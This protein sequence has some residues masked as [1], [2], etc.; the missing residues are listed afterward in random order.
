MTSTPS[1]FRDRRPPLGKVP[2]VTAFFWIIKVLC[3]TVGETASDFLNVNIG[4]GLK[5]TAVVAGACLAIVLAVQFAVKKYIP[6]IY[7]LAVVLVSIF[8]TLVTDIL[9][10]SIHVPLEASAAIFSV[11]LALTFT[12]WY[13]TERTLS[14]HSI[15]TR[16]REAFY[17]LAILFTFALGTATG[18]LVAEKLGVGYLV[19]GLLVIGVIVSSAIAWRLGLDSVLAFWIAYILTRPLGASLG[20]YLSQP[21]ADGGLGLG[22]TATSAVFLLLI[23]AVVG[24][25]AVS[26]KD[27]FEQPPPAASATSR[28][29]PLQ[30]VVVVVVPL[31]LGLASYYVRISHL[32]AQA[33]ASTTTER[34]LGDLSAF[35]T[36]AHDLLARV[37]AGDATGAKAKADALE[38][39][40]DTAQAQLQRMNSSKWTVMDT[41]IDDVLT[42]TRASSKGASGAIAALLA[43]ID[44]LD[45]TR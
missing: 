34:P 40:W 28:H 13:V 36:I 12:A 5:G 27:S 17:W 25:L 21:R 7:W 23:L 18:D 41:A 15:F 26:G 22:A 45:H 1:T 24:Y 33:T 3:T 20:D 16:R 6:A 19:T 43:V 11:V 8:G 37:S 9:T 35:R 39:A 14:I 32:Q 4:L 30:V 10:D 31:G 42:Q 38:S 2:Y 44:V 29:V